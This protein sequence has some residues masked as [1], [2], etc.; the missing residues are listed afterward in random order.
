MKKI[1]I[2]FSFFAFTFHINLKSQSINCTELCILNISL[3]TV[4]TN[5]L[6]VSIYNGGNGSQ[7]NY[8]VVVVTNSNGDT[9]GNKNNQFFYFAQL[10]DDTL[11]HSIPISLNTLVSN[12]TGTVY[13][14]DTPTN[15]VCSFS[16]PMTC[17]VGIHEY[18]Q[19][20]FSI[21]PNPATDAITIDLS[22]FNSHIARITIY[23]ITGKQIELLETTSAKTAINTEDFKAG[24]YFIS[25]SINNTLFTR[26]LIIQ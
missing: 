23:D 8:P 11:I 21:Y 2:L 25:V 12:F 1:Y 4:G 13:I 10:A 17:T 7:I 24:I 6:N 15:T 3:D 9:I 5:E 18:A 19:A 20:S 14:R 16:Y 26:K 22:S